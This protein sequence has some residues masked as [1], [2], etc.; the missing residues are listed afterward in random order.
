MINSLTTAL[1]VTALDLAWPMIR[2]REN[3]VVSSYSSVARFWEGVAATGET[4]E[5]F[6]DRVAARCG[7]D[8]GARMIERAYGI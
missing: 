5:T 6:V 8:I 4:L 7:I 1:L 3:G 2:A